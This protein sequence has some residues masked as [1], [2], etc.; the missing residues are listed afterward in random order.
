M[1]DVKVGDRVFVVFQRRRNDRS[2]PRTETKAVKK[3]GRKYAYLNDERGTWAQ[4]FKRENGESFHGPEHG[5]NERA[6]GFGFDVY[7]SR[8]EWEQVKAGKAEAKRLTKRLVQAGLLVRTG[9]RVRQEW[10]R[11]MHKLLDLECVDACNER[12]SRN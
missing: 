2:A 1:W 6:N 4:R 3:V 10:V 7:R 11:D 12:G 5:A 8:A 9:A